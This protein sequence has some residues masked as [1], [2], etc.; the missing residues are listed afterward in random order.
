MQDAK[1]LRE[2][3]QKCYERLKKAIRDRRVK[4]E[5]SHLDQV[6]QSLEIRVS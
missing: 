1:D 3:C 6:G 2:H 5:E 4:F